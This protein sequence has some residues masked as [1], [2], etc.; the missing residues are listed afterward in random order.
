MYQ[1]R[2]RVGRGT[3][4][5][6]A[7]FLVP[8][9]SSLTEKATNRLKAILAHQEL[10]S[11]FRLAMKDLEIRGAGNLL[12]SEQSGHMA[13]VGFDLYSRLLEEAVEGLRS[14]D[15]TNSPAE[16]PSRAVLTLPIKAFIPAEYVSDMPQRLLLYQRLSLSLIHIS[17][18]RD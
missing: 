6:Y 14:G 2:G 12:G 4:Q 5:G 9:D 15:T 7:Y 8:K 3:Y 10:G 11:G 13:A 18:P 1:L 17:S 16:T